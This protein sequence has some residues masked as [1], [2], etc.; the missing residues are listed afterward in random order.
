MTNTA[1]FY[2]SLPTTT[3]LWYSTGHGPM[4]NERLKLPD[5]T[6]FK[7]QAVIFGESG[8]LHRPTSYYGRGTE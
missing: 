8:I 2:W 3:K 4:A 5:L 1:G 7:V 6:G